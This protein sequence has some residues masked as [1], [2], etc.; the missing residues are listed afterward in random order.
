M[1]A[2]VG[3]LQIYNV[4]SGIV[5]FGDTAVIS[6]KTSSKTSTGSGSLSTSAFVITNNALSANNTANG[7]VVDQPSAG[8][9]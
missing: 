4:G 1:P 3:P 9:H 2:I 8:N 5:H 6:P 7:S